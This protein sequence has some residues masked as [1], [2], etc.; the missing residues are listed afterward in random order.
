MLHSLFNADEQ[1]IVVKTEVTQQNDRRK[2]IL[3]FLNRNVMLINNITWNLAKLLTRNHN[4]VTIRNV[5]L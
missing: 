4:E 1:L 5:D 3:E 2:G